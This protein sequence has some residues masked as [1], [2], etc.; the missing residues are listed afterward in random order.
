MKKSTMSK[1]FAILGGALLAVSPALY[2]QARLTQTIDLKSWAGVPVTIVQPPP[3]QPAPGFSLTSITFNPL[4]N[5][6]Y[7][8]DYATTN[9]YAIDSVTNTVTSAVYTNG[10]YSTADIGPK[11]QLKN[12]DSQL[13]GSL[14]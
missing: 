1:L 8:A 3:P 11:R 9:V 7:V 12:N 10:L 5:T 6:I 13:I 14:S 2:A 4:S